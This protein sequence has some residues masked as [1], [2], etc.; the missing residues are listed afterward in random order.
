MSPKTRGVL[1]GLGVSALALY[2]AARQV[3]FAELRRTLASARPAWLPLMAAFAL[4][5]L[6]FRALRWK[7]LLPAG[8]RVT[9]ARSFKLE[10]IGLAVNN[11]LPLRLGELARVGLGAKELDLPVA[12]LLASVVVERMLDMVTLLALIL[13]LGDL[14]P[15]LGAQA[16]AYARLGLAVLIAALAV[17]PWLDK[18]PLPGPLG[19]PAVASKIEALLLGARALR[20][21]WTLAAV[22]AF[23]AA[24]W[25]SDVGVIWAAGRA[26]A[27]SVLGFPLAVF[28]LGAGAAGAVLPA[29]P[30]YVG[31]YELAVSRALA[32]AGVSHAEAFGLAGLVH[33]LQF[34]IVTLLGLA[35]LYQEGH[36]LSSLGR[37]LEQRGAPHEA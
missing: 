12:T 5:D 20:A 35:F 16:L 28:V 18:L 1:I 13:F 14:G 27:L 31:T 22:L 32:P 15:G 17:L 3:D 29:S 11:L 10:C 26:L 37:E 7:L 25:L 4:S 19:R 36:S 8:P 21:P 24:L 2:L 9:L 23:G 30:G 6:A 33:I 34:S